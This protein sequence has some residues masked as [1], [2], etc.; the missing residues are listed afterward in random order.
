M[1]SNDF[2]GYL[3]QMSEEIFNELEIEVLKIN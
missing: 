3:G 2:D 1:R